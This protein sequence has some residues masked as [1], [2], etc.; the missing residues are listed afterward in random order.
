[1]INDP[2][3]QS[4]YEA[5]REF[6]RGSMYRNDFPTAGSIARMI[7]SVLETKAVS[8]LAPVA[9]KRLKPIVN[10]TFEETSQG[11]FVSNVMC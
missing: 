11:L 4:V 2:M 6:W 8:D 5:E 1:M 3:K 9:V 7:A 10:G